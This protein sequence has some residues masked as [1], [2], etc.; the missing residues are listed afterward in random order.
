MSQIS[1]ITGMASQH[2]PGS[3]KVQEGAQTFNETLNG[4]L[5]NVNDMIQEAGDTVEKMA[6]GEVTDMH[7]VMIA[8]EKASIGLEMVLEIRNKLLESYRELMRTQI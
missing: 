5:E 6:N 3:R 8:V 7:Q 1:E 2:I 4:Y